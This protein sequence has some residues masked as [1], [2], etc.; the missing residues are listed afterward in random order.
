MKY[1]P[2]VDPAV[3]ELMSFWADSL[4]EI[5]GLRISTTNRY[6]TLTDTGEYGHGLPKAHP[7]VVQMAALVDSIGATEKQLT[8]NLASVMEDHPL[9]DW[10]KDT[11]GVGTKTTARY[12]A[13]VG[14]DPAWHSKDERVRTLRE[15][16]SYSGL[17]VVS[18][19][20]PKRKRG[21]QGNWNE[22]ARMRV[23]NM[24]Q[25]MV[26]VPS[27]EPGIYRNVYDDAR[28]KY[29]D[30]THLGECV[31]CGPSGKPAKDGS[32]LNLGHKHARAIRAIMKEVTRDMWQICYDLHQD[33]DT[34]SYSVQGQPSAPSNSQ[35]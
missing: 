20:A 7:G 18:G 25:P 35:T 28:V 30:A 3:V 16:W 22:S 9:G 1:S 10:V 13:S 5:E 6:T 12:L 4:N 19:R 23:W 34:H 15:L 33:L 21:V 29:E 31:R 14:G 11:T 32:D 8:K 27:K 26:R 2:I 24:A 17:A